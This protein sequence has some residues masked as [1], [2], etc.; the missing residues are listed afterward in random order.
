[1]PKVNDIVSRE[2]GKRRP[3]T[4]AHG[5]PYSVNPDLV[6]VDFSSNVNPLGISKIVFES[7]LQNALSVSST[8]PDTQCRALKESLSEYLDNDLDY[9]WISVGNGASE[10]IHSFV[11][12]FVRKKVMI[13]VPTFC[14][15]EN[16]SKRFGANI[17]FIP[18]KK[19]TLD[20]DSIIE[21]SKNI[22]AI[23]L[24]NP[25][26]P[27]G[28]MCSKSI[29]RIIEGVD[30]STKILV[31]ECFIEL[32][33]YKS[34]NYSMI[35]RI[36]EFSNLIIL[37]S[38]TKSFGLA[39]L[40]IGYI[41][42]NPKLIERLT[43]NQIPWNVNGMAQIAGIAALKDL[44]HLTK[45]RALIKK[46]RNF[47]FQMINLKTQSFVPCQSV[48]N[49]YLVHLRNKNSTKIRDSILVRYGILV[50]D[51]SSFFG[52]GVKYIRVAVRTRKENL[53]LLNSL[54]SV[55]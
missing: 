22:D 34:E 53:L 3:Y 19:F 45:S 8:Y 27:T 38:M 32:S 31:D 5:G 55:D 24:C 40:R 46:E 44:N 29:Q 15:Y 7:I 9:E 12:T 20:P 30:N 11:Q 26:N 43:Y 16:A 36:K 4:C 6:K 1:M 25:N 48:A 54:E 23:F 33:D 41:I 37:R 10:L 35:S 51:C 21:K 47:M 28:L 39:G 18:L 49:Y 2:A 14:E 52:M 42:C 50:R 13:P 17:V